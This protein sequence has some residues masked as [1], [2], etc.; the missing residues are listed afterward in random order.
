MNLFLD[1]GL[2]IGTVVLFLWFV[3][4]GD[5]ICR[6]IRDREYEEDE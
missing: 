6:D 5:S 3:Y 2:A 4:K 1:W